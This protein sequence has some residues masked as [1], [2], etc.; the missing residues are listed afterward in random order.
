MF[1]CV[2]F[3][4]SSATVFGDGAAAFFNFS[5]SY[6]NLKHFIFGR[7]DSLSYNRKY[8]NEKVIKTWFA[9]EY[10][11]VVTIETFWLCCC[12][13]LLVWC[14]CF[15]FR[16]VGGFYHANEWIQF[17]FPF[18]SLSLQFFLTISIIISLLWLYYC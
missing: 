7:T 10:K 5:I 3:F 18:F 16:L 1:F 9:F 12:C 6:V 4:K 15:T 2:V 13:W 11:S 8:V 17:L 14:A